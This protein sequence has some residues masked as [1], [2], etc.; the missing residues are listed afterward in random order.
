MNS[1][2]PIT[3][4]SGLDT[5]C[6]EAAKEVLAYFGRIYQDPNDI[7]NVANIIKSYI[8]GKNVNITIVSEDKS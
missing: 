5:N 1:T 4:S 7:A 3:Y 6:R 2:T 8:L